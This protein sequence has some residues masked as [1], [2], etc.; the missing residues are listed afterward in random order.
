MFKKVMKNYFHPLFSFIH[1]DNCLLLQ[2][3]FFKNIFGQILMKYI[4]KYE[5]LKNLGKL[6]INLSYS[7]TI[8]FPD[9]FIKHDRMDKA[10][11]A[12]SL[13]EL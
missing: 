12:K 5:T 1:Y 3:S 6:P 7:K 9:I 4:E 10:L 8:F 2:L 13:K 11:Y